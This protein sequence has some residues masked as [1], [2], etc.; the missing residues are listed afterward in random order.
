MQM[1][2]HTPGENKNKAKESTDTLVARRLLDTGS[3]RVQRSVY[4]DDTERATYAS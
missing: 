4:H 3:Q 1:P 2:M